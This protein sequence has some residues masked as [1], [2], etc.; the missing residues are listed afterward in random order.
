MSS[1][2]VFFALVAAY[3]AIVLWFAAFGDSVEAVAGLRARLRHARVLGGR[4][5]L[6][7]VLAGTAVVG[8]TALAVAAMRDPGSRGRVDREA[9]IGLRAADPASP[10][11]SRALVPPATHL[12][13]RA[14]ARL[15]ARRRPARVRHTKVVSDLVN[16]SARVAAPASPTVSTQVAHSDGPAPLRAPAESG[17][18]SP[19]AAP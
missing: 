19:L 18:P 10:Q 1:R 5:Y 14:S 17:A 9:A 15:T 3:V 8:L 6:F 7:G 11:P 13:P 16:V 2:T 12:H 4:R